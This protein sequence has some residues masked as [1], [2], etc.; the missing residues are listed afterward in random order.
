MNGLAISQEDHPKIAPFGGDER[1][2]LYPAVDLDV[3]GD[4]LV[5]GELDPLIADVCPIGPLATV[6]EV[7]RSPE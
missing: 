1:P 3:F 4:G 5:D 7:R 2:A 6:V